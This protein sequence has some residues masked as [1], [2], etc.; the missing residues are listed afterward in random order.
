M[1]VRRS[2]HATAVAA[3]GV[4]VATAVRGATGQTMTAQTVTA[5]VATKDRRAETVVVVAVEV[6]AAARNRSKPNWLP[7]VEARSATVG[8]SGVTSC[9]CTCTTT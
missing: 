8:H 9:A 7:V 3:V 4:R 5:L 1:P 6:A 2:G